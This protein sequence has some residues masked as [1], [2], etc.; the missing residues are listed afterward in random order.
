MMGTLLQRATVSA[1]LFLLGIEMK[2]CESLE[3]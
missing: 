2:R 1:G 3:V